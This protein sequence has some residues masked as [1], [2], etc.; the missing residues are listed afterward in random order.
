[1]AHTFGNTGFETAGT[2]TGL[3]DK[4]VFVFFVLGDEYA[5]YDTTLPQP[6]EDFEEE[7][8]NADTFYE[9]PPGSVVAA[10]D[11]TPPEPVED[12]E[13][14]WNNEPHHWTLPAAILAAY[15]TTPEDYEDFEE[16]WLSNEDDIAEFAGPELTAALYDLA[17][18]E[19]VEDFEEEWQSNEDDIAEF[20]GP[21]LLAA[22]FDGEEV[23]DFEE[24]DLRM[25]TVEITDIGADGD[26]Y[27]VKINGVPVVYEATGVG[28]TTA[29]RDIIVGYI[30][31][32]VLGVDASSDGG[33]KMKLR[34]SI[35]GDV[36]Q[37]QVEGT[38][39]A[40]IVLLPSPDKT[41]YWT[42][43]GELDI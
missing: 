28:P 10:Y 12:F 42:Q 9:M 31:A 15:D 21:E 7:W 39:S 23:E 29:I 19:P 34:A 25:Y 13:E 5:S 8:G 17:P 18:N 41:L 2:G 22:L 24:V 27:K 43:T 30:N 4:W 20:A 36:F 6:V 35:S 16:E 1:M 26:V 37:L 33:S 11:T 32:A 14:E 40:G 3:A 38:G